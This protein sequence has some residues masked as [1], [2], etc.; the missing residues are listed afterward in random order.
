MFNK[1]KKDT[2]ENT[3]LFT[4]PYNDKI[5]SIKK[6][7][8]SAVQNET[9]WA[10][11]KPYLLNDEYVRTKIETSLRREF[12]NKLPLDFLQSLYIFIIDFEYN[13]EGLVTTNMAND[14]NQFIY[15]L[16]KYLDNKIIHR[17]LQTLHIIYHDM[18]C[19]LDK[20]KTMGEY[21]DHGNCPELQILY[22]TTTDIITHIIELDYINFNSNWLEPKNH[23]I[24]PFN[25]RFYIYNFLY[26]A[27]LLLFNNVIGA[28]KIGF[29]VSSISLIN[30][31]KLEINHLFTVINKLY[32]E[33]YNESEGK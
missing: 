33:Q 15:T 27:Q 10:A 12:T 9:Y 11:A 2:I 26:E 29:D 7:Y 3:S 8:S 17:F 32:A 22:S 13:A 18:Y 20:P 5:N 23:D 1:N 4:I 19:N 25:L 21:V 6:I 14:L 31:L 16:D 30:C 24:S 28:D